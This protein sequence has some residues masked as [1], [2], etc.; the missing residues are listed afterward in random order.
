MKKQ[1]LTV[2]YI[3]WLAAGTALAQN[4]MTQDAPSRDDVV[5][6]L[7]AVHSKALMVQMVDGM[8]K[9][10]MMGMEEGF[11]QKIP[12][13]TPEQLQKV[14]RIA[15]IMFKDFPIDEIT[16]AVIPIYQRHFTKSDLDAVLVF[17]LSPAGQKMLKEQPALLA[18]SIQAGADVMR[19][20]MPAI[21]QEM[22]DQIA[23]LIKDEQQNKSSLP[24][25]PAKN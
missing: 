11:K 2:V 25:T 24:T 4:P 7:D 23:Q 15:D 18:E 19:R 9:Q 21:S 17:Y 1:F 22:Q 6:L 8:K 10:M 13:A 16:D 14:D 20:K 5:R 12:D 3:L